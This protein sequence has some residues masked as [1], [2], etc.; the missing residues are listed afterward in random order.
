MVISD[1]VCHGFYDSRN[2]VTGQSWCK[3]FE[4]VTGWPKSEPLLTPKLCVLFCL[5]HGKPHWDSPSHVIEFATHSD[6]PSR[7]KLWP[8]LSLPSSVLVKI[9]DSDKT[10]VR[11]CVCVCVCCFLFPSGNPCRNLTP[12]WLAYGFCK[13]ISQANWVLSVTS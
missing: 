10:P 2:L 7:G 8:R 6:P 11:V 3:F 13:W 4:L 12:P 5:P 9:G 1:K